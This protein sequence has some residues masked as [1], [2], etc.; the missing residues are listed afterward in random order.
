M[1]HFFQLIGLL[2]LGVVLAFGAVGLAVVTMFIMLGSGA[3]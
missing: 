1:K 3:K 2:A